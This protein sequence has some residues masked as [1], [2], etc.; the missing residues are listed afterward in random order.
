MALL[1]TL[2]EHA[3]TTNGLVRLTRQGRDAVRSC[4]DPD[5]L[6]EL[7]AKLSDD[8]HGRG[9]WVFAMILVALSAINFSVTVSGEGT[10]G[11]AVVI[12]VVIG[13]VVVAAIIQAVSTTSRAREADKWLAEV[14]FRLAQLAARG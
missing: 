12:F 10:A 7:R 13:I 8:T 4:E 1:E 11:L 6:L 14:D 5:A 3:Y 9:I 2:V